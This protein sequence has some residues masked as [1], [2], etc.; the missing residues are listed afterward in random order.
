MTLFCT[1]HGNV[2]NSLSCKLKYNYIHT[3]H[4]VVD[5]YFSR[6]KYGKE[7]LWVCYLTNM[8]CLFCTHR[9]HT[10]VVSLF[11]TQRHK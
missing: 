8:F 6:K 5:Y 2:K 7:I 1:V 11:G 9:L 4:N 10:G 3:E